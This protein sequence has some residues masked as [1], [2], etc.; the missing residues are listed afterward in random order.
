MRTASEMELMLRGYGLTTAK[1]LYHYPDHPHLLQTFIWQEYDLAPQF[2]VLFKF[3]D[4]WRKTLEGPLHSVAYTHK[5]L[6]APN[7]W[8]KVDGEFVLH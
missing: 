2:P 1:I 7:E 3:L 8:R 6:I 5:R 4:F